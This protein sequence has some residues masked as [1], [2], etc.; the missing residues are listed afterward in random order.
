MRERVKGRTSAGYRYLLSIERRIKSDAPDAV[1]RVNN[2]DFNDANSIVAHYFWFTDKGV[3]HKVIELSNTNSRVHSSISRS[4]IGLVLRYGIQ[5]NANN[6]AGE[7]VIN[8]KA[9]ATYANGIP[10]YNNAAR[11]S[12]SEQTAAKNHQHFMANAPVFLFVFVNSTLCWWTRSKLHRQPFHSCRF[13][14]SL[15]VN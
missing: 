15:K 14:C 3:L 2:R 12:S 11:R 8:W 13:C 1:R 9:K 5:M 7:M 6:K 10:E 4:S